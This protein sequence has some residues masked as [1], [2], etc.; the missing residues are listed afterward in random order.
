MKGKGTV[1]AKQPAGLVVTV[2]KLLRYRA[3]EKIVERNKGFQRSRILLRVTT[4][5][6]VQ[7]FSIQH[8]RVFVFRHLV[9]SQFGVVLLARVVCGLLI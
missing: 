2:K 3:A 7:L 8:L 1:R 4:F 5:D 9:Q 6:V